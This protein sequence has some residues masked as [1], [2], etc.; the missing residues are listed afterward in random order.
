MSGPAPANLSTRPSRFRER[1][2]VEVRLGIGLRPHP[3]ARS[4]RYYC[5]RPGC[6]AVLLDQRPKGPIGCRA[7][8]PMLMP[9]LHHGSAAKIR[10]SPGVLGNSFC[11]RHLFRELLVK[12]PA[13]MGCR[14]SGW[15]HVW[16]AKG[17]YRRTVP[18]LQIKFFDFYSGE[19]RTA[20]RCYCC[21]STGSPRGRSKNHPGPEQSV[22]LTGLLQVR[23]L[24]GEL[25]NRCEFPPLRVSR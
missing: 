19:M 20:G 23:V 10:I 14:I 17:Q 5:L 25:A 24:L 21:R 18:R 12:R 16:Q 8:W 3:L 11:C 6:S 2:V 7:P 15:K 4:F 9:V 1:Q 22:L 13:E